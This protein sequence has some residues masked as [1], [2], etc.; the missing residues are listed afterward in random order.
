M[1]YE[2]EEEEDRLIHPRAINQVGDENRLEQEEKRRRRPNFQ[3]FVK[4]QQIDGVENERHR[5]QREDRK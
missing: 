3:G 1:F 2:V 5:E 4:K